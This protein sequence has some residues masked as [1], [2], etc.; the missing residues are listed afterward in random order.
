[1]E[2]NYE[3]WICMMSRICRMYPYQTMYSYNN[4]AN[5]LD[6]HT[7]ISKWEYFICKT[8]NIINNNNKKQ[9]HGFKEET[10]KYHHSGTSVM[11]PL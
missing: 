6:V 8:N 2:I 7:Q 1:M 9:Q 5:V 3:D 11:D 10:Q 4:I